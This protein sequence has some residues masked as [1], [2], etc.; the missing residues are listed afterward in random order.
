VPVEDQDADA[1]LGEWQREML[2]HIPEG[3]GGRMFMMRDEG[4]R[5]L[6][7]LGT[8]A[9]APDVMTDRVMPAAHRMPPVLRGTL[10]DIGL[11]A[12]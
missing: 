5:R 4:R 1:H 11:R 8:G 6:G 10:G 9:F 7:R 12:S 3:G 2:Q